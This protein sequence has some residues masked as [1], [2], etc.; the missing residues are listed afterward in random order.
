MNRFIAPLQPRYSFALEGGVEPAAAG[1]KRRFAGVF[2]VVDGASNIGLC[3]ESFHG[4]ARRA[5][6]AAPR[7]GDARSGSP[8]EVVATLITVVVVFFVAQNR[9]SRAC[10][11]LI[12]RHTGPAV[13]RA[14]GLAELLG[15]AVSD[16]ELF[17]A[18]ATGCCSGTP[19][20][21]GGSGTTCR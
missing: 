17:D 9:G 15:V 14:D 3:Q 20:S 18:S 10:R 2:D 1:G 19:S 16:R 5:R 6:R 7:T 4:P 12:P 21:Y 13:A 8:R 11:G